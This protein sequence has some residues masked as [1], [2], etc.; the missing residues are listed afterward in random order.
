MLQQPESSGSHYRNYKRTDSIILLA[1]VGPEYEFLF[2]DVGVNGRNSD[3]G[4]LSQTRLKN[5]LEKNTLNLPDPAPLPGRNYSLPYVCTGDD[6]FPLTAYMMK[7]YP[8]ENLSL[9]KRIFNYQLSR[10]R[11]ISENAFGILVNRWRVFRKPFFLEPEKVKAITLV[12]LTLYNWLRKESDIG[13]VYFS[14]ILVDH[15]DPETGE[16]IEGSWR[17]EI[18]TESWKSSSNTRAHN[19][20]N[21]AK[22][23]REEFTDYFTNEGCIPWQW[24]CV[25]VDI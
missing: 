17:K 22:T 7:P 3:G 6:A 24:K 4:N 15:E 5:G 10:M 16:I 23:I 21:E 12:V 8:Q 1:I 11:R 19:P 2:V 13:K 14:P 9:E 20:A 25:R 18:L